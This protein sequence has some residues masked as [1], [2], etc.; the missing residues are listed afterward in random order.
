MMAW[1]WTQLTVKINPRGIARSN[2]VEMVGDTMSSYDPC[3]GRTCVYS[4]NEGQA[5]LLA[6]SGMAVAPD[7]GSAG[8]LVVTGG[9]HADYGGNEVYAFDLAAY[10]WSRINNPS[11]AIDKHISSASPTY[12]AVH[13]EYPDGSPI[14][15]HTYNVLSVIPGGTKGLL[16]E[17]TKPALVWSGLL[18]SGWSHVCDLAT[19]VWS[20]YS[21]NAAPLYGSQVPNITCYDVSRKRVWELIRGGFHSVFS[22]LDLA[23]RLHVPVPFGS[24]NVGTNPCA[25]QFPV[26]DLM[27]FVTGVGSYLHPLTFTVGAVDLSNTAARMVTLTLRGD[28]PPPAVQ[29]AYGFDWDTDHNCGYVFPG[30]ST[31]GGRANDNRNVYRIDPPPTKLLRSAWTMSRIALPQALPANASDGVYS[32]WRYC[33]TIKKFAYLATNVSPVALWTPPE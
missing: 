25:A 12:D 17:A 16:L 30:N 9:G 14:A 20:R 1:N 8:S 3:R 31:N 21:G 15:A 23:S 32:R 24:S 2:R 22:Y 5:G 4:G 27:L 10:K 19:G 28:I 7:L 11:T 26:N 18:N 6:Y 13:G 29:L 33:S